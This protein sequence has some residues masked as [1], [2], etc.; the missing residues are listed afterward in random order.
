ME[1]CGPPR[2]LPTL[3]RCRDFAANP[4]LP[5]PL[6]LP[7]SSP[8]LSSRRS[9]VLRSTRG[10]RATAFE[11]TSTSV[12]STGLGMESNEEAPKKVEADSFLP[13]STE[14]EAP[15]SGD[16]QSEAADFLSQLNLK[17]DSEDTYA[18]LI[19]GTG[20]LVALWIS[21]AVVSAIDSLPF[22]PKVMEI[23]GL[24]FTIWFSSRYL[25]FKESRD[26]FF[27]KIDELKEQVLGPSDD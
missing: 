11:E 22:F 17:L 20:A 26:E 25:I 6:L 19:Y 9:L 7:R 4:S 24:A 3:P 10:W 13:G 18:I 23:V 21:F 12:V 15:S 14:E 1:L 27:A 16:E 5:L 8:T 2:A